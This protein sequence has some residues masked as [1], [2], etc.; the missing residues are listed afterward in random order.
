[1]I[2]TK[3][4]YT[5]TNRKEE[6]TCN[7]CKYVVNSWFGIKTHIETDHFNLEFVCKK[8]GFLSVYRAEIMKHLRNYHKSRSR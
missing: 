1:M 6:Y 3:R 2:G 5:K 8:C 7:L 4:H